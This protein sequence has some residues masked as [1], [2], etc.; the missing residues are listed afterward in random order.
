MGD[1]AAFYERRRQQKLTSGDELRARLTQLET[2]LTRIKT[3]SRSEAMELLE[4]F[5][6]VDSLLTGFATESSNPYSAEATRFE[7]AQRAVRRQ[8]ASLLHAIGGRQMLQEERKKVSPDPS[9]LWWY[10]D[11]ITNEKRKARLRQGLIGA[12]AAAVLTVIVVGVYKAYFEPD[13][14]TKAAFSHTYK[15]DELFRQGNLPGALQEVE[16]ALSYTPNEFELLILKGVLLEELGEGEK[17]EVAFERAREASP[18]QERF[19]LERAFDYLELGRSESALADIETVLVLNPESTLGYYALGEYYEASEDYPK[20]L[21]ALQKAS[22]LAS[23][24]GDVTLEATIRMRIAEL[25]Q[26]P[27]IPSPSGQVE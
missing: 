1:K 9:R 26:R 10:V 18:D 25:L 19:L 3:L 4:L 22:E 13:E 20:A 11:R 8:A 6:Q 12:A 24:N 5:D 16:L 2:R 21:E 27:S 7:A 17:A 15:A 23:A 14:A